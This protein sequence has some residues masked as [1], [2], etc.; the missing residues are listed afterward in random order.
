MELNEIF[1][2]NRNIADII[3]D[4]KE[5]SVIVIP[6][7]KLVREYD[8]SKHEIMTDKV[9]RKDKVR[10]DGS[11]EKVARVTYGMQR[12]STRRMT[13]MAFS[14]PVKRNYDTG[15]DTVKKAIAVA[16]EKIYKKA[17]IDAIN[18]KRMHA[19]F[20]AC[21]IL[22]IWYAVKSEN[23][24]YGFKSKYKLR[25][26]SFSPMDAKFSR[27]EQANLYPLMQ[28][29]DMLAMSMEYYKIEKKRKILYFE[30]Y[31]ANKHYLWKLADS[32]WEEVS[33]PEDIVILK[34]PGSYLWRPLPIWEDATN[35][36]KEIEY[37][38]S[39]E[40]DIIRKNSAPIVK[41]AGKLANGK[42]AEDVA[43]EVY[44]LEGTG[45]ISYVTWQ[46]QVEAL[47]FYTETLKK[48]TEE[49]LQLPNLSLENTKG[50]GALSGEAR[51][52]LLTDGHL[53]VGDES[54]DIIEFLDR[55]CNIIKAFL[56]QMNTQ[57]RGKTASV[58]VEHVITPF[59]QNDEMNDIE[60][61]TKA[62]G[63]KAIASRRT[64]VKRLG[65]VDENEI[66]NEIE[67]IEKEEAEQYAGDVF[68]IGE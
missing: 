31:I 54:G 30:T 35:N 38:L 45:D 28:G 9:T 55:E 65:W 43:R 50:L 8:P 41:I 39:R 62:T 4:L 11:L 24:D 36:T 53:K 25:C 60:K 64:A 34:I 56:E 18:T 49:E 23:E 13:Q 44:Q 58:D 33:H 63:G 2:K 66:K 27:I 26:M 19:Y 68:E 51:K 47:K 21:E 57:W 59:I 14:I 1:E 15:E 42:T 46:Q 17:R 5:K 7:S 52:T 12:I 40:S 3:S 10:P 16:I 32:G 29:Q 67:Q 6:W 37:A 61:N 22:S 48:N 20:A